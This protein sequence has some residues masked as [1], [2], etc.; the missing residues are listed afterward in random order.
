MQISHPTRGL[1]LA[2]LLVLSGCAMPT[3]QQR[4][5]E[6]QKEVEGMIAVYGPACAKLGYAPESDPW[7]DCILRLNAHEQFKYV[8][9]PTTTSCIGHRGFYNCTTF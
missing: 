3:P 4:A 6:V 7:R 9:R 8:N 1:L 2:G 5:A